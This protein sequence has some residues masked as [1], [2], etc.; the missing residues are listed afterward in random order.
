MEVTEAIQLLR[1]YVV[2]EQ[3]GG[4]RQDWV[5]RR[6]A[7]VPDS[8]QPVLAV[9]AALGEK[10]FEC[11]PKCQCVTVS[12]PHHPL[13][14]CPQAELSNGLVPSLGGFEVRGGRQPVPLVHKR[15]LNPDLGDWCV[16][17]YCIE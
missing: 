8:R 9:V 14:E 4:L 17:R 13:P 11:W 2:D 5:V 7:D 1:R 16:C 3:F 10:E 15:H 6:L 12:Q